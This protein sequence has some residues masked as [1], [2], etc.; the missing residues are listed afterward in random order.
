MEEI[1][2]WLDAGPGADYEQGVALL[3]SHSKN[4]NLV[5]HLARKE[6]ATNR[7]KLTYELIKAGCEGN[8]DDVSA[9]QR[10]LGSAVAGTDQ[11]AIYDLPTHTLV[12]PVA[13]PEPEPVAVPEH[14]RLQAD[15][16]TVLMQQ[17]YNKRVQLSN[18]LADLAA[19]AEQQARVAEILDLQ[20]QY[21]A[22]AEK[23]RLVLVGPAPAGAQP[24][25][26]AD[27][28]EQE[29]AAPVVDKA[30][31]LQEL[32]N[33]RSNLSKSKGKLK[34]DPEN[35]RLKNRVAQ[36]QVQKDNLEFQLKQAA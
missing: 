17:L 34:L 27:Q 33:V 12:V 8:I 10:V 14:L 15:D 4:R 26:A 19:P 16:L 31:L 22:L 35:V 25:G 28:H 23:R 32:N 18:T 3:R 2:N 9:I 6:S 1:V 36:L 20:N 13:P 30:A 24:A 21:N 11:K 7:E 29:P 5:N